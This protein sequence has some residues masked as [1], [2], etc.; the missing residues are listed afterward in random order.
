M[1]SAGFLVGN[2]M[3]AIQAIPFSVLLTPDGNAPAI[4]CP[5]T[6]GLL[7]YSIN[8]AGTI[9]LALGGGPEI[10]LARPTGLHSHAE[11]SFNS[12]SFP[13]TP[14]GQD[15]GQFST[16]LVLCRQPRDGS[17]R[18]DTA[19]VWKYR[20][21]CFREQYGSGGGFSLDSTVSPARYRGFVSNPDGTYSL[22][23]PP[24]STPT[25]I[26]SDIYVLSMNDNGDLAGMLPVKDENG[27]NTSYTFIRDNAGFFTLFHPSV[28]LRVLLFGPEFW[29]KINNAKDVLLSDYPSAFTWRVRHPDGSE[30]PV[31]PPGMTQDVGLY[32][33]G[34][35][36]AGAIIDGSFLATLVL[37]PEGHAAAVVCPQIDA[38]QGQVTPYAINDDG[39]VTGSVGF[40]SAT[41]IFVATPTGLHSGPQLSFDNW[42]FPPTPVGEQGA[43]GMIY[44]NS[45]GAADLNIVS[46]SVGK[47]TPTDTPDDFMIT[48]NTCG[49]FN[50][51][52]LTLPPGQSC[53]V[54]FSFKPTGVGARDAEIIILDDAPDAPHLIRLDGT[55]LGKGNLQ[56]SNSAWTFDEIVVGQSSY[57]GTIYV[58][59]P[60]TDVITF[61]SIALGGANS[62]D[63]EMTVNTCGAAVAPYTTCGVRFRFTPQM[64]GLRNAALIFEDDSGSGRQLI[65]LTGIS[66]SE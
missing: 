10:V 63:F 41:T 56:F 25:Q 48:S 58:Y 39:V 53:A 62:S 40:A 20:R 31:V 57:V 46:I 33:Y 65:P 14:V 43:T 8:D 16:K 12:W 22:I 5:E 60:G 7:A 66:V 38:T 24:V 61:S 34:W 36:N 1:N 49:G 47:R 37:K 23:D 29:P 6:L 30:T 15:G 27:V 59:N 32:V 18:Y 4:V 2:F 54:T 26:F 52:R 17:A 64:A 35:N 13:P 21:A 45:T 11:L 50:L 3:R 19:V 42:S 28:S 9:A 51:Q 44:V 55:G